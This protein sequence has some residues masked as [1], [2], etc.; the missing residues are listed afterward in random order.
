MKFLISIT[1]KVFGTIFIYLGVLAAVSLKDVYQNHLLLAMIAAAL[2][3]VGFTM[4][5]LGSN[6]R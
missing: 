2:L 3:F 1:A 6:S 5:S 4:I